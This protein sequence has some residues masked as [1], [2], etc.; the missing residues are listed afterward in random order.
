M[1][2]ENMLEIARQA[3]RIAQGKG[4]QEAAAN[5]AISRS[6]E[7]MWRDGKVDKIAEA[8]T[9]GVSLQLYVDGRYSTASTSDLRPDALPGFIGNAV[10][11]TRALA[12]DP[13]RTLPD[14]S[15]YKG[16]ASV[17]LNLVDPKYDSVTAV[18]RRRIAEALEASA[19]SMKGSEAI[20]SVTTSFGDESS[21]SF[22]VHSNGFEGSRRDTLFS[23]SATVTVKDAD[24]R[25]PEEYVYAS[26]RHFAELP[27]VAS[28]G[29][30]TTE[31]ALG[32]RGSKKA[33]SA[34]V[35]VVIEN[36]A[37]SRLVSFLFR[38]L[39]GSSLQQKRSFLEKK[40]GTAIGSAALS[41]DDDPLLVKGLS[42][43]L[44]DSEGIAAKR[45]PIFSAGVLK[46]YF[47]DTYY[48]KKLGMPPTTSGFSNLAWKLGD[49]SQA[50][51]LAAMKDGVLITGFL[52]GNSNDTTGDFSLGVQGYTV[53]GGKVAEPIAEM[54]L[55]GNHLEIWKRLTAVGN[56][57][58]PHSPWRTP[59]LVFDGVQLAGT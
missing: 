55:S 52:G 39:S 5:A 18:E 33:P 14:P 53:R 9:R 57:P 20:L 56:D 43:R 46:N 23:M 32:R 24:G 47:I 54:N 42:S 2:N 25:R 13:L 19:R 21:E 31:R 4:A 34:V 1:S 35:A 40:V 58:F 17:D 49:K 27:E 59:T 41:M 51:L 44:Y 37:A 8:T 16:Q 29:R 50:A 11:M 26:A 6:V 36:R 15:L 12:K 38:S 7:V 10:A 30:E 45:M 48:G 3:I 22:R 28:I